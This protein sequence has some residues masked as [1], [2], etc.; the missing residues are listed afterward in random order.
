MKIEFKKNLPIAIAIL[1][2]S[3]SI[4]VFA[5]LSIFYE[6]NLTFHILTQGSGFLTMLLMGIN[7]FVYQKQKALG[8][9]L[10]LVSGFTLFV[11]ICRINIGL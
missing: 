2:S 9:F 8:Y 3:I 5:L 1:V 4:I 6:D 11:M 10:W 7:S